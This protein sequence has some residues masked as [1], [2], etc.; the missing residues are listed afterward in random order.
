MGRRPLCHLPV[1][2]TGVA[3]DGGWGEQQ[4][5]GWSQPERTP[6]CGATPLHSQGGFSEKGTSDWLTQDSRQTTHLL[7]TVSLTPP[8]TWGQERV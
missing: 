7:F 3:G 1:T 2:C 8:E 6:V 4:K 5:Q